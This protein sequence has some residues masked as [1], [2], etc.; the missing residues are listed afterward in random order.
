M[1]RI[2][3]LL[4]VCLVL[5]L[6]F[7]LAV[8]QGFAVCPTG[9]CTYG[10]ATPKPVSNGPY[11]CSMHPNCHVY[12]IYL[13]PIALCINCYDEVQMGTPAYLYSDHVAPYE[14]P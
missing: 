5:M 9:P 11:P 7:T 14:A 2:R 13:V 8:P 1:H 6:M 4:L 3:K 12:D 10:D